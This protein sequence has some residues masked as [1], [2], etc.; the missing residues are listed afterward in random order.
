V[1]RGREREMTRGGLRGGSGQETGDRSQ[2]AVVSGQV[3][4]ANVGRC[5]GGLEASAD[6]VRSQLTDALAG[7]T[8]ESVSALEIL[9]HLSEAT[10][11]ELALVKET[12][13][14]L[15]SLQSADAREQAQINAALAEADAD[16]AAGR[17]HSA[18]EIRQSLG[19]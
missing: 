9:E 10:F 8:S 7:I 18:Q 13:E 19:L 4:S 6:L 5:E 11:E 1:G 14:G 12:A 3:G 15:L 17:L 2:G 16:I